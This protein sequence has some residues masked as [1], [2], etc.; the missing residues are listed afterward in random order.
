MSSPTAGTSLEWLITPVRPDAFFRDY[1][2][3]KPLLIQRRQPDFY[4]SLLTLDEVDR[5]LTT[6]DLR[7]PNVTLKNANRTVTSADYTVRGDSLDVAKVYQLFEEGAT[8]TLAFLDSVI[9]SLTA[10]CRGLEAE[11]SSPFQS[12]VYLTPPGAQGAKVHFDSHDVFVLQVVGSKSWKTYGTPVELPLR[13]QEFDPSRHEQ[14]APT[15][16]FELE[17]GDVA[18][19]PR[20][21]LHDARSGDSLSLHIT[22]GVLSYT[23]SDLLLELVAEASLSN[24]AFRKA[25]PPGFAEQGF[26][27]GEARGTLDQLLAQ[28]PG[29]SNLDSVL[30]RFAGDLI[31]RCAPVLRGQM[32]Q[33]ANL[34]RLKIDST[35][36]RRVGVIARTSNGPESMVVECYGRT[37]RFPNKA[38]EA[39]SFA[40]SQSKFL[41]RDLPGELDDAGKLT[42]VRRLVREGMVVVLST[43]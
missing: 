15:L 26:D 38:A 34:D 36:G 12:N 22:V 31:S 6:L 18:Y 30:G 43:G 33:L 3:K 40:L 8:I 14:G 23:W 11:F 41:V 1:W 42:L 10:L 35:V 13:T 28:L 27:R 7:Y 29:A 17:A 16:E 37:I 24:R 25:L 19:I 20:G 5:A 39:V 21:V 2:E 9:P 32:A 4:D